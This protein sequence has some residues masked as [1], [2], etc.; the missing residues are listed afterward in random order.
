[1]PGLA[2]PDAGSE[3]PW[4]AWWRSNRDIAHVSEA[5]TLR[6]RAAY[7]GLVTRLDLLIGQILDTLERTGLGKDTLIVYASDHGEQLGER[8]LWW[9]HTLY[10]ESVKV[11][12]IMSWPGRFPKGERRAQVVNLIDLSATMLDAL[13]APALPNGQ[14]ISFLDAACDARAPWIDRTVSE[15]CTD[16]VPAWTGGQAVQQ[17]MIR[18]GAWKLI[19][20][21]GYRPQ[22]FNLASDPHE[23]DDLAEKPDHRGVR[24]RLLAELL[25]DW[26]PDAIAASMAVRR[27]DKD[28][29]GAWA[30]S[31]R[32]AD[33]HRW[34]L[35]PEQNRLD[36]QAAE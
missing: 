33:Q 9:K 1:M 2:A 3:H 21:H 8:G 14:G 25:A 26:D 4:L 6:S 15:Y 5:E 24:D 30:R 28:L 35:E 13:G 11:P 20:Y 18:S 36:D 22:L 16:A 34:N 19:Y 27:K 7:Y 10:D 32:P 29:L 23:C 17:R 12:L 31:V